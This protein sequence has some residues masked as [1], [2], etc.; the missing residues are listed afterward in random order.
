MLALLLQELRRLLPDC[1]IA[2]FSAPGEV[3]FYEDLDFVVDPDGV[4]A[5][6]MGGSDGPAPG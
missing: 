5:M 4:R 6:A 3:P 1:G 2:L